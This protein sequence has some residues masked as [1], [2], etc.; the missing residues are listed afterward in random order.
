MIRSTHL[1]DDPAGGRLLFALNARAAPTDEAAQ[2]A[3]AGLVTLI[4]EGLVLLMSVTLAVA[5]VRLARHATRWS[6]R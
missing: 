3:T 4:P 2:T 5:A 1:P 6:S